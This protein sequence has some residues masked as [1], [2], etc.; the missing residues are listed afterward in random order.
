MFNKEEVKIFKY[1]NGTKL[2]GVDP[3]DVQINLESQEHFEDIDKLVSSMQLGDVKALGELVKIG[4]A[5]FNIAP[6]ELDQETGESTGLGSLGVVKVLTDFTLY[7]EELKKNGEDMLTSQPPT[8]SQQDSGQEQESPTN[9]LS[10][11][12]STP[13]DK[14]SENQPQLRWV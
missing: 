13:K 4:R 5:M 7:M 10:E 3:I 14:S 9:A 11:C 1:N 12:G 8:D 6:L 2:V